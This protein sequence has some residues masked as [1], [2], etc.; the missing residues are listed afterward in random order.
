MI[1]IKAE[2]LTKRF[3]TFIAVDNISFEINQGEVFGLLGPNGAGKTTTISMLSTILKPTSG[4]AKVN[5]FDIV[6]NEDDV[7][8]SIGIVFQD[9]SLDDELTA[10]DNMDLHARLYRIDNKEKRD[11]I[12]NLLKLVELNERKNSLVKTF[13]GGM[14]RRLEI[15]RGLLHE[16]KVLFLDEPTLGLDPQTRN[17]LWTYIKKLNKEK[18]ITIILTTHYMDEADKLCDKVAIIDKGKIIAM[19]TSLNLKEEIGGDVVNIESSDNEKLK[20]IITEE[21]WIKKVE[22][23]DGTATIHIINAENHISDLVS[24]S[25]KQNITVKSISIHKPSLEDVFLHFTGKTI[26][27]EEASV[28]DDMRMRHKLWRR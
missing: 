14:K 26:R 27:E 11:K 28:K 19:N 2:K 7:R 24:I 21:K 9:Q 18:G 17:H 6:K 15:A 10:Y 8:K 25:S 16:P 13:S 4:E 20:S 1:S 3:G 23:H 22:L 5:G 12:E